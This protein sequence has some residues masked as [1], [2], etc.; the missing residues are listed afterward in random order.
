MHQNTWNAHGHGIKLR[1]SIKID[2]IL[3]LTY[4]KI[5]R[6]IKQQRIINDKTLF[7]FFF[8]WSEENIMYFL[9]R[10]ITKI[11]N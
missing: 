4:D 9:L 3:D 5:S 8:L 10:C 6:S 1:F 2:F 7:F 11:Q